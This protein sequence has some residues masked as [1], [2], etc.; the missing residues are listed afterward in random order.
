MA[1]ATGG[2][3]EQGNGWATVITNG[4]YTFGNGGYIQPPQPQGYNILFA[5]LCIQFGLDTKD[6]RDLFGSY[7]RSI[8]PNWTFEQTY[9]FLIEKAYVVKYGTN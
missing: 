2:Y 4:N 5:S 9:E 7:F 3:I 1:M 8:P 6:Q